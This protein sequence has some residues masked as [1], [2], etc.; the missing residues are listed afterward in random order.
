M[1]AGGDVEPS[2]ATRGE[3]DAPRPARARPGPARRASRRAGRSGRPRRAARARRAAGRASTS[4]RVARSRAESPPAGRRL[5]KSASRAPVRPAELGGRER[6]GPPAPAAD[7]GR[8]RHRAERPRAVEIAREEV[9]HPLAPELRAWGRAR[10]R[11]RR[12]AGRRRARAPSVRERHSSAAPAPS[13]S[14]ANSEAARPRAVAPGRCTRRRSGLAGLVTAGA[15]QGR[16]AQPRPP[17][18]RANSAAVAKRSAGVFA[19]APG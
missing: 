4:S 19:R 6:V 3:L 7:H 16:G 8:G 15:A 14:S 2:D 18:A 13:A 9:H 11:G 5:P 1:S 10:R 12:R 17:S